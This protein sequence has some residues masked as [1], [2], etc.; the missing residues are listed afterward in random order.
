MGDKF[1]EVSTFDNPTG[2]YQYLIQTGE[3]R[4]LPEKEWNHPEWLLKL[5]SQS[6]QSYSEAIA[7]N[8]FKSG[9]RVYWRREFKEPCYDLKEI[10]ATFAAEVRFADGVYKWLIINFWR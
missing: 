3:P 9:D 1:V 2:G 8:P 4:E 5:I 7:A 6:F 10:Y